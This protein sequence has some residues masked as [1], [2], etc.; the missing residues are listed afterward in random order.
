MGNVEHDFELREE[1]ISNYN[2][3]EDVKARRST[4]FKVQKVE[5]RKRLE[6]PSYE[7]IF[8]DE[9]N[10]VRRMEMFIYDA[11]NLLDNLFITPPISPSPTT[12]VVGG[13]V[14]APPL[15]QIYLAP[16]SNLALSQGVDERSDL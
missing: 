2:S 10:R 7:G 15:A 4:Y 13:I 16:S 1:L 8:P 11:H 14:V 3:Y 9:F 5:S 12:F 6:D